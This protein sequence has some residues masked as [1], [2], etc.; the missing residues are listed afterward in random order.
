MA[1]VFGLLFFTQMTTKTPPKP[2]QTKTP[3]ATAT[4]I[5]T[6]SGLRAGTT[7]ETAARI[8]PAA[9]EPAEKR[10]L[11][12]E[13]KTEEAAT[14][15]A[16]SGVII[17]VRTNMFDV[18]F[19][20]LGA[21]PRRWDIIAPE[22]LETIP[23]GASRVIHIIP[24]HLEKDEQRDLP[25]EVTLMENDSIRSF[26]KLNKTVYQCQLTSG[27]DGAQI[28]TCISPAI[29]NLRLTKTFT[30]RPN[31]YLVDLK[32]EIQNLDPS[33]LPR[34]I[35]DGAR[36]FGLTLGPGIG[37]YDPAL[38]SQMSGLSYISAAVGLV[39]KAVS[40]ITPNAETT[41]EL[42]SPARWVAL[43][44]KSFMAALVAPDPKAPF[45]GA[46]SFQRERNQ[47][48]KAL[49]K[50]QSP[51][52]TLVACQ[53]PL[54]L[55]KG[56]SKTYDYRIFVGPKKQTLLSKTNYGLEHILFYQSWNWFRALCLGM[57]WLL[58]WLHQWCANYGIA[59]ILLTV[60]VRL[61]TYPLTH[62]GMK[63]NAKTQMEMARVKPEIEKINE[64]YKSDFQAKNKATMEVYKKHNINPM[65]PLRGCI[66][67]LIQ[68]PIFIALY[69][70]LDIS[71]DLRGESFLWVFDLSRPD[72]LFKLGITLPFLGDYFNLLPILMAITTVVTQLLSM[73]QI[74][75]PNQKMMLYMMPVMLLAM[76]YTLSSGLFV[77]W[78]TSNILQVIQQYIIN[79]LLKSHQ[80]PIPGA[81]VPSVKTC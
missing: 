29:H 81:P 1:I 53:A 3:G 39:D 50:Q 51:P 6:S 21:R 37:E 66:P 31:D 49:A 55:A 76:T 30:F 36:G 22:C 8:E 52:C 65:A 33:S 27:P 24:T 38:S 72:Q 9:N 12:S 18:A 35:K 5:S 25:L 43:E 64:K 63:L 23:N 28:L 48:P 20:T 17:T 15:A 61:L 71:V 44:N 47:L 14:S 77:Y 74:N 13:L 75:D 56:A 4:D 34:H 54:D 2:A 16:E 59:I 45:A 19:D 58:N 73:T 70:L 46:S 67:L 80:P 69:R 40:N 26:P 78:I 79:R 11:E 7:T 42:D 32:I 68:L 57:M 60:I 41:T 62:H 10:R